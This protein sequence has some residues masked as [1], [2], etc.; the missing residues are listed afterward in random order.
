MG[1][2]WSASIGTIRGT[3]VRIHFTFLLLI[4]WFAIIGWTSGGPAAA[5]GTV[6]F[7]LLLFLCVVLHEFGHIFAARYFGV[8]TPEVVLLPIGGVARLERIPEEP[9][10]EFVIALAGPLVTLVIAL[11]LTALAGGLPPLDAEHLQQLEGVEALVVQ[12][13]FAN[14]F[15][16]VFNLLP[17]FPMDGGRVL[18]AGLSAWFGHRRGT[19][20]AAAIGQGVAVMLG[21]LGIASQNVIL[22]LVAVFVFFA[23]GSERG[24]VEM[25]GITSGRPA[26]ESM[27]THFVSLAVDEPVS[28]A[29]GELIHTDQK[30]FPVTDGHGR[31]RGLLTRDGII[32]ALTQDGPDA[33]IADY[34]DTDIPTVTRWTRMDDIVPLL[35]GG[36][37]AVAV[38]D[39]QGRCVGFITWEN[40][41]EEVAI[42]RALDRRDAMSA[43]QGG[44][45]RRA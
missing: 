44:A 28:R 31:F 29:A 30:E 42:A 14:T 12:L 36:A 6:S 37:S 32:R 7:I 17:A 35:A 1:R 24:I 13:A 33:P 3:Q 18:R 27:I 4:L 45:Q 39:E 23:A 41:L 25:R 15:L 11:V 21:I 34:V 9:R 2:R 40:V 38:T 43:L 16:F 20:I 26:G 8:R 5:L 10:A 19:A 22:V